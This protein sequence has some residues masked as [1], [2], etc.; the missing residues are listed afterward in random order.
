MS[1]SLSSFWTATQQGLQ[2]RE[3]NGLFGGMELVKPGRLVLSLAEY[4]LG[5][6]QE[7]SFQACW[8]RNSAKLLLKSSQHTLLWSPSTE[9]FS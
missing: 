7:K 8:E 1:V 3:E 9:I 5:V 6:T 4:G 2:N